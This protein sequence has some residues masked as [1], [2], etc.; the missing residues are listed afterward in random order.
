MALMHRQRETQNQKELDNVQKEEEI[1]NKLL[2]QVRAVLSKDK[3]T[4]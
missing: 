3:Q 4:D 2:S 1:K